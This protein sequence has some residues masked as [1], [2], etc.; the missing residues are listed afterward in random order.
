[1]IQTFIN[2]AMLPFFAVSFFAFSFVPAVPADF[3][4][5]A[6]FLAVA[7]VFAVS[8]VRDDFAFFSS[9]RAYL[10]MSF[11]GQMLHCGV[12]AAQMR[13]PCQMSQ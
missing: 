5:D 1:M 7:A 6:V 12:R 13:R 2:P 10:H 8:F 4:L 3:D 11:K 9:A